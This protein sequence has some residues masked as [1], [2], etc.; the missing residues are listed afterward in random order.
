M[1][2]AGKLKRIHVNRSVMAANLKNGTSRPVVTVKTAKKNY[3]CHS[4]TINGL[5]TMVTAGQPGPDGIIRKRLS[6]GARVYLETTAAL[7]LYDVGGSDVCT[8][9]A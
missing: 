5:A 7:I 1:L 8:I 3:Y 6:C 9:P 4:V 2:P